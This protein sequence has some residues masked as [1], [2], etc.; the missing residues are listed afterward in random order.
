MNTLYS[1]WII[2]LLAL[3]VQATDYMCLLGPDANDFFTVN[4][5]DQATYYSTCSTNDDCLC[6][7]LTSKCQFGP[8][9]DKEFV[10][11]EVSSAMAE[12]CDRSFCTCTGQ[13]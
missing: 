2:A 8:D 12:M 7:A 1:V 10:T 9:A 3:A 13:K 4:A 6:A 11:Q 5:T